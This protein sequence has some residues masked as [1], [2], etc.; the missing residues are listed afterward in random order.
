MAGFAVLILLLI[1]VS[2]MDVVKLV[3]GTGPMGS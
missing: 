3:N 2:V 1:V